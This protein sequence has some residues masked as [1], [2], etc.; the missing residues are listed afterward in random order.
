MSIEKLSYVF[1]SKEKSLLLE[2][3]RTIL[4]ECENRLSMLQNEDEIKRI[5]A[6]ID[7]LT[8][9]HFDRDKSQRVDPYEMVEEYLRGVP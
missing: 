1:D 5:T 2:G 8:G 9:P 7:R 4:W 3:L 6:L